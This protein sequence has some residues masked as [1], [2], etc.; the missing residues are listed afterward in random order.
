MDH[1]SILAPWY[2]RVIR[3]KDPHKLIAMADLPVKGA[4]LDAGGGTGRIAQ[5]LTDQA[6][7][8]YVSDP[9]FG[10]LEQAKAKQG[11]GLVCSHAEK[12]C[13]STGS[14]DRVLMIDAFHHV[15]DQQL[16]ARELWR[17]LK[18]GGRLVI[19]EPDIRR[20]S[21]KLVAIAEK[22]A[23]MRSRFL[24][25]LRISDLFAYPNARRSIESEDYTAW[26][27]VEKTGD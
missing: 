6:G 18:P 27:I 11:L 21:I 2:D 10:M 17:V 16:S 19:E 22:V 1:F 13:F 25:P 23:L 26:I 4:I 14:F 12:L 5:T 20:F 7:G 8:I 9:S 24:D 15:C 3:P